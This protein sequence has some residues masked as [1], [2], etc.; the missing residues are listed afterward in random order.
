M[1]RI[2]AENILLFLVPTMIYVVWVLVAQ[3]DSAPRDAD[4][5]IAPA[6]LLDDAPFVW[7]IVL[8]TALVIA[9]IV[10]FRSESGGKPGQHYQPSVVKD[11]QI[12][13]GHID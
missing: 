10:A 7:L 9:T 3:P 4:G 13:P 5:R 12:Q 1:V 8:G 6:R 2:I 11:G